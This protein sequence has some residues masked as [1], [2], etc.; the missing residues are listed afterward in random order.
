MAAF[1]A[2]ACIPHITL[3]AGSLLYR[4]ANDVLAWATTADPR[5]HDASDTDKTGVWFATYPLQALG[6]LVEYDV[7][8]PV[9]VFRLHK[10]LRLAFG[11]YSFRE[12][13]RDRYWTPDGRLRFHTT[14]LPQHNISHYE[15]NGSVAFDTVGQSVFDA[16]VFL[17]DLAQLRTLELLRVYDVRRAALQPHFMR[18]NFTPNAPYLGHFPLLD[19]E[20][21]SGAE[22][23]DL[24][25]YTSED[26][27]EREQGNAWN[28]SPHL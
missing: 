17:A 15:I 20:G 16:E 2:E 18:Y 26:A 22:P 5:K 23:T 7:D 1:D 27:E 14:T 12:L 4:A 21:A 6:M 24:A 13:D 10:D 25:T 11:K 3:R 8:V 28:D 19:C 9:A